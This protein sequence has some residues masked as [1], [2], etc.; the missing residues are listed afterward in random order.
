MRVLGALLCMSIYLGSME[1]KTGTWKRCSG[2][3]HLP[4]R[5]CGSHCSLSGKMLLAAAERKPDQTGFPQKE[6]YHLTQA[7]VSDKRGSGQ[8][9]R[10]L[11]PLICGGRS[12]VRVLVSSSGWLK[13][14]TAILCLSSRLSTL[15][16]KKRGPSACLCCFLR[17]SLGD[18]LVFHWSAFAHMQITK[19]VTG[20]EE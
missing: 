10:A 4:W 5:L 12:F 9:L 14:V 15:Q 6:I 19:S 13:I 3:S 16:R 20:S 2:S 11:T 7:E 17:K 8:S 1:K 18:F